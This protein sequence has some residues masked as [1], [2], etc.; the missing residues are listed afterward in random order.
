[1]TTTPGPSGDRVDIGPADDGDEE[2]ASGAVGDEL[3]VTAALLDTVDPVSFGRAFVEAIA[4]TLRH[5]GH[6][7][8]ATTRYASGVLAAAQSGLARAVGAESKGPVDLPARDRRFADPGWTSNAWFYFLLEH[9]LLFERF[10]QDLVDAG[11]LDDAK[12]GKARFAA[13]VVADALAPSNYLWSNP[14]VL[15][16]ALETGGLSIVHG[17]RNFVAD[18]RENDGF[19]RKVDRSVF[20]VGRDLAATPGK[21]VYRNDL[22]EL[23][24]YAPQTES[25]FEI[26]MLFSP[27]WINKYYIMDLKPGSS[28]V[29]WAVQHHH[30]VFII[31]YRNPDAS[32]ASVTMDDYLTQ[33]LLEAVDVIGE[34]TGAPQVNVV[35]LC[36]GGT[37]ATMLLAYLTA[38]GDDRVR[39]ATLTNTLVDF[40]DP[41]QLG[42]F[43]D[44]RTVESLAS[45]ISAR[46][47]LDGK[48]MA[49]TFDLLRANDLIWSYVATNWLMGEQPP[50]FELL[51]WN[52]DSTNMPATMHARYLREC[53]VENSLA[54]ND[55]EV[56]G[57]RLV[58]SDIKQDMYVLSAI[59]DHIA[60]WRSC[61]KTTQLV[62]GDTRFVLT[63]SGHIAGIV[64]P[65]GP[66]TRH[67]TNS[68]LDPDPD[69]WLAGAEE[70]RATW[71]ED[72]AAWVSIR[73][74]ERVAARVPGSDR[75][76]PI[77]DAPGTYV[78]G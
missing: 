51:A 66:K 5:P 69:V 15:R 18:V 34:I 29:E 75:Y 35:A 43:A 57:V 49:R 41:G 50:P 40:S 25:V 2:I 31:S 53:Y 74:G 21:V 6:S 46:G 72:W 76:P 59:D 3:G 63:S 73:A 14:A 54:R 68:R 26:P 78:L 17:L 23:I 13:H 1:M 60:P 62:Q 61:Y 56:A 36:L 37:L 71:W 30:T 22:M 58:V 38:R 27:A 70:H 28:F 67:W 52:D 44:R 65:P 32:M 10:L 39:S 55:L 64:N 19:P 24:Q 11:H 45:R 9:H 4:G 42:V 16:K 20:T 33:G 7:F 77:A 8:G 48:Q 12:A 47:Y